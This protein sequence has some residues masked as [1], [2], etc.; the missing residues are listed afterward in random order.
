MTEPGAA[1]SAESHRWRRVPYAALCTVVGLLLGWLPMF[2]HGPIPQKYNVLYI[3]GAIA[4]WGWYTARLLIGFMV[5]ITSWPHAWYLR[6]PLVGFL[7]LFPLSLVSLAT[8]GCQLPCMCANLGSAT[9]LG[10]LV[11]AIA[12]LVTGRSAMR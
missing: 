1:Q 6:G 2:I 12:F 10:T 3:R 11:A 8:P 9:V 5:G 7:M 4:V